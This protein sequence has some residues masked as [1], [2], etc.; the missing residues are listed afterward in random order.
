MILDDDF[1]SLQGFVKDE[2]NLMS[3][4]KVPTREMQLACTPN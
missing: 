1:A 3:I 4:I 2:V